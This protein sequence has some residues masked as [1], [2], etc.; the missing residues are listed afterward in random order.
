MPNVPLETN[1]GFSRQTSSASAFELDVRRSEQL[2]SGSLSFSNSGSTK[3]ISAADALNALKLSVGLSKD[4]GV[5][6]AFNLISAHFD[7]N[8]KVTASDALEIL[9]Y[10]FGLPTEQ[11]ARW[12]FLHNEAY[13]SNISKTNTNYTERFIP[14]DI[15]AD[16]SINIT[17]VLIGDLNDNY[18]GLIA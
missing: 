8:G 1:T 6:D 5:N 14:A 9:K 12:V 10:S 13:F 15:S 11:S 18:N 3:V 17:G 4:A 7:Q 2:L 16:T